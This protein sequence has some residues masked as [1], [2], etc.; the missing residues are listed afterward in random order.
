MEDEAG[1]LDICLKG[2]AVS[3]KGL[4]FWPKYLSHACATKGRQTAYGSRALVVQE[5]QQNSAFASFTRDCERVT[6]PEPAKQLLSRSR[7]V[8]RFIV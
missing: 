1:L 2:T 3:N 5:I 6:V 8:G 7:S 4:P